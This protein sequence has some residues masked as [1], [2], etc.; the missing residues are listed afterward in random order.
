VCIEGDE[1]PSSLKAPMQYTSPPYVIPG[2]GTVSVTLKDAN[3]SQHTTDKDKTILLKGKS[4]DAK[5]EVKSPAKQPSSSGTIPD[6][7]SSYSGTAK[8]ISSNDVAEAE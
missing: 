8:F 5:F 7:S 6:P 4:F 2:M 3:K 1:L